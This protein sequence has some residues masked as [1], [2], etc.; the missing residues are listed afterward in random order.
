MCQELCSFKPAGSRKQTLL[1][2]NSSPES[3]DEI[4]QRLKQP[5]VNHRGYGEDDYD[6]YL[7]GHGMNI[8][9]MGPSR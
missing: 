9:K 3:L 2:C 5:P 6:D 8:R 4:F 7:Y 1:G